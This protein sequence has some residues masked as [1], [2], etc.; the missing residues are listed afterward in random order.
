MTEYMVNS[1]GQ[2]Y[3]AFVNTKYPTN[4]GGGVEPCLNLRI[5]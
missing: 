3:G 4:Q 1:K 2:G 5:L